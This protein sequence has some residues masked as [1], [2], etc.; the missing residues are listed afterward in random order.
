MSTDLEALSKSSAIGEPATSPAYAPS[1]S[2]RSNC[3][4]RCKV[5]KG[6]CSSLCKLQV[7]F[8]TV[9]Y[10]LNDNASAAAVGLLESFAGPEQCRS[11]ELSLAWCFCE[12][13]Q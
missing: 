4:A 12:L 10:L 3:R 1:I 13:Q 5:Q 6:L 8:L 9:L 11:A 2:M 7:P